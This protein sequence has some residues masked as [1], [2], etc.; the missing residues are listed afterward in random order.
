VLGALNVGY[1]PS[2]GGGGAPVCTNG[3]YPNYGGQLVICNAS[4]LRLKTNVHPFAGG[5]EIVRQLHPIS[6]N[7]KENG[8][9]DIGLGA[10]EVA[11]VAPL[12]TFGGPNG[13]VDGVRYERLDLLLINAVKEQQDQIERE[14]DVV[15]QQQDQIKAAESNMQLLKAAN[16]RLSARLRAVESRLHRLEVRSRVT[17]RQR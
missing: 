14:Q 13:E 16:A 7:W 5:L 12:F 1:F 3:S 11:K 17:N 10:E 2:F 9:S 15:K 4:S 8:Q 6:F